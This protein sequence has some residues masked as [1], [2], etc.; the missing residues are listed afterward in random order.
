VIS[1]L[2]D[3][4]AIVLTLGIEVPFEGADPDHTKID[5]ACTARAA[6]SRG[7]G[8]TSIAKR[9]HMGSVSDGS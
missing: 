9:Q 7:I 5:P 6:T 2:G 8:R 3:V 1:V 4:V